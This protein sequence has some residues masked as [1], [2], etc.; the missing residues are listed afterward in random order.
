MGARERARGKQKR[1]RRHG[2]SRLF[3]EDPGKQNDIAMM[4]KELDGAVHL[5][6]LVPSVINVTDYR[7]TI[8]EVCPQRPDM[9]NSVKGLRVRGA[10]SRSCNGCGSD[11]GSPG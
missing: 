3:G 5:A 6:G 8:G 7:E 10:T 1:K 9:T 11:F 2:D 4:E